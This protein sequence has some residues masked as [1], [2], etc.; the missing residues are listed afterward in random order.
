MAFSLGKV[1]FVV[2]MTVGDEHVF[3]PIQPWS[4]LLPPGSG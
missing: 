3:R 2:F 4:N 1:A